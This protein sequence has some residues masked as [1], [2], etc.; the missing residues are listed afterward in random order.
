MNYYP[1]IKTG[2]NPFE[3]PP[4]VIEPIE[5]VSSGGITGLMEH[6]DGLSVIERVLNKIPENFYGRELVALATGTDEEIAEVSARLGLLTSPFSKTVR[7][8]QN[9]DRAYG[10]RSGVPADPEQ[11]S[12]LQEDGYTYGYE[13]V[14]KAIE[15]TQAATNEEITA[16]KESIL[17]TQALQDNGNKITG[18]VVSFSEIRVTAARLLDAVR[19]IVAISNGA[20]VA[21]MSEQIEQGLLPNFPVQRLRYIEHCLEGSNLL[22]I[23]LTLRDEADNEP[24][25]LEVDPANHWELAMGGDVQEVDTLRQWNLMHEISNAHPKDRVSFTEALALGIRNLAINRRTWAHCDNCGNEFPL[26]AGKMRKTKEPHGIYCTTECR[27]AA[28]QKRYRE[29]LKSTDISTH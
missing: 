20:S 11:F 2:Q 28:S 12:V 25:P 29:K 7:I 13:Q 6:R 1:K 4:W 23:S 22:G 8:K 19:V 27:N 15:I 9:L 18:V 10:N 17:L 24:H 3:P 21:E 14:L 16:I 5:Q 26:T